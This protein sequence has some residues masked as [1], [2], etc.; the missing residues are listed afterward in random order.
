MTPYYAATV[1]I[2]HDYPANKLKEGADGG[3]YAAPL[4][5]AFMEKIHESLEDKEIIDVDP[6]S[7]GL[8]KC[9]VCSVSGLLATEACND[10]EDH[11][12]VTDWFVSANRPT[13]YCDMH[14]TVSVCTESNAVAT[15]FCPEESVQ[16]QSLI[17][18]RPGSQFYDFEDEYLFKGLPSAVRTDLSTEA[19][20]ASL[21]T[22]TVHS[23]SSLGIFELKTRAEQLISEVLGYLA[24]ATGLDEASRTL[25]NNDIAALQTALTGYDLPRSSRCSTP[26]ERLCPHPGRRYRR[27]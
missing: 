8:V 27:R 19:Y 6:A 21:P 14:V 17:L 13:Q 2:G 7:L 12:P 24:D 9:T 1:W 3:T 26:F 22:C 5:K 20:L 25:L 16:T 23:E 15:P 10:D 11:K 18:V 4:W